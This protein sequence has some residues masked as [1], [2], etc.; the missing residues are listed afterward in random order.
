[1]SDLALAWQAYI[2]ILQMDNFWRIHNQAT[3]CSLRDLIAEL[4]GRSAQEVQDTAE[5]I[6]LQ[7]RLRAK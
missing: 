1:M 5:G 4:S 3:Y 2:T 7:F 6:A